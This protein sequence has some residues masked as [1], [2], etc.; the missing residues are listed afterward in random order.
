[1]K[2]TLISLLLILGS[3]LSFSQ[4]INVGIQKYQNRQYKE[5]KQ[6]FENIDNGNTD[7]AKA[8]YYLGRIAFDDE[9]LDAAEEYFEEAIDYDGSNA[10][11]HYW[12][13]NTIGSIAQ[14]A[15]VMRQ[16]FLAPKV[17]NAYETAVKLDPKMIDAHWGLVEYYTLAPGFM[18]GSWEKAMQAARHIVTLNE[19]R[20]RL[21]IITV[22]LRQEKFTEAEKE[23]QEL[24]K[25]DQKYILNLGY[26]YQNQKE[27]NKAFELFEKEYQNNPENF[28]ALYQIGRT[29]AL[30]G[31]KVELGIKCL[32][33]YLKQE[34]KENEPSHAAALMRLAMIYETTGDRNQA[35]E[36]YQKSLTKEPNM[37]LA[38]E[39]LAR[40]K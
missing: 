4:S 8:Q 31:Q 3:S 39:G 32:E 24:L 6:V 13:G 23:Y 11:Y 2:N 19:E 33:Q 34:P 16:G 20:G 30:S 14:E 35:K 18:G 40:V 22:Y 7:Y 10:E 9:K 28:A 1:M 12:Y 27:Y 26:F 25:I 36:Y 38:K 29:S 37:K 17:K 15:N 21:A 5:A